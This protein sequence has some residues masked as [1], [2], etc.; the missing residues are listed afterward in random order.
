MVDASVDREAAREH[1]ERKRDAEDRAEE[2]HE[3]AVGNAE[4]KQRP[5]RNRSEADDRSE[6]IAKL[7]VPGFFDGEA[8]AGSGL[9]AQE[10]EANRAN[11][12]LR[13]RKQQ[14]G[15]ALGRKTDDDL[16]DRDGERRKEH[17]YG[18]AQQAVDEA[19]IKLVRHLPFGADASLFG[20][21]AIPVTDCLA[22]QAQN[23]RSG[24]K[25]LFN[26]RR[27]S[28][29]RRSGLG[30][31]KSRKIK[32]ILSPAARRR[33]P[34]ARSVHALIRSGSAVNWPPR[35]FPPTRRRDFS[36]G[37]RQCPALSAHGRERARGA[38]SGQ[39]ESG[40]QRAASRIAGAPGCLGRGKGRA[41]AKCRA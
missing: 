3:R 6:R 18:V 32:T 11:E 27:D 24:I 10:V 29:P 17:R 4:G 20:R 28:Y 15:F 39:A 14:Q 19:N 22:C 30:R 23:T 2:A 16:R 34:D 7:E 21:I 33:V 5:E 31:G 35:R 12:H 9:K 8:C 36:I 13:A 1:A 41:A 25:K 40:D 26:H 37:D 38:S